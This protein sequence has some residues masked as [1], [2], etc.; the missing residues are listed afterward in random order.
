MKGSIF[1]K[2]LLE[3]T[4]VENFEYGDIIPITVDH[5]FISDNSA[6][7]ILKEMNNFN[8]S[9]SKCPVYLGL[10]YFHYQQQKKYSETQSIIIDEANRKK[11]EILPQLEGH[12]HY[13]LLKKN[14][15]SSGEIVIG[16]DSTIN[17]FSP[18]NNLSVSC[19]SSDIIKTIITGQMDYLVPQLIN[20]NLSGDLLSQTS[21]KDV[22]LFL[23][24][25]IE[26]NNLN[27]F[28]IEFSGNLLSKVHP[29]ELFNLSFH[30]YSMYSE[31]FIFPPV[32]FNNDYQGKTFSSEEN[33]KYGKEFRFDVSKM[34]PFVT[35]KNTVYPLSDLENLKIHRVFIGNTIGGTLADFEFLAKFLQDKQV[36]I[37]CYITPASSDILKD[38]TER[39]YLYTILKAGCLLLSPSTGVCDS[40]NGVIT[41]KNENILSSGIASLSISGMKSKGN[42]YT[43]S[44]KTAIATAITGNLVS[45]KETL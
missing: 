45:F 22:A 9:S 17:F 25:E 44:L 28:M 21:M 7:P 8:I 15:I 6:L 5:I 3:K 24:Q 13:N 23:K 26:K 16:T 31:G 18:L 1:E 27:H 12:W 30:H 11:F 37:P 19:G 34:E 2:L 32:L 41:L 20:I 33:V 14:K 29:N 4:E 36:K 43:S 35:L 10:T 42:I 39:G 38:A 40:T